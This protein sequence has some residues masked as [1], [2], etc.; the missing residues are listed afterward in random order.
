MKINKK[1]LKEFI[2]EYI[3]ETLSENPITENE[4]P[5][6]KGYEMVGTKM[7]N[8]KEVPNCVPISEQSNKKLSGYC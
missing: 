7:K 5:C 6:W 4:N 2:R 8:G 1:Q 3:K